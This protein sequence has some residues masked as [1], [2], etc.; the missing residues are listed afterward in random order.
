MGTTL[1]ERSEFFIKHH[2][3]DFVNALKSILEKKIDDEV[4]FEE[5]K[6]ELETMWP[7]NVGNFLDTRMKQFECLVDFEQ[8][9]VCLVAPEKD[10]KKEVVT[11]F[12]E[13]LQV[14]SPNFST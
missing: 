3:E 1:S 4:K 12:S 10:L 6:K 14:P 9:T 7:C 5:L 13:M 2:N 8:F 11:Y